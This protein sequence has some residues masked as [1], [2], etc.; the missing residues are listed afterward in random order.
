MADY[1]NLSE[2][3]K[4]KQ[5]IKDHDKGDSL[6]DIAER[7]GY[8]IESVRKII[9]KEF[10]GRKDMKRVR[11]DGRHKFLGSSDKIAIINC[12][13]QKP[14]LN[15]TIIKERLHLQAQPRSI[16]RYLESLHYKYIKPYKK[17]NLTSQDKMNR[18]DWALKHKN[19]DF[20]NVVFADECSIWMHSW[21]GKMWLKKG[22][23]HYIGTKAYPKVHVW[24]SIGFEGEV[25][26]HVFTGNLTAPKFIAI[27]RE[28]LI[29]A[30]NE[31]YGEGQWSL[32]QDNDPKH[33]AKKT[34]NFLK[35]QNVTFLKLF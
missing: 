17:P 25:G 34:E 20:S 12:V 27:L 21:Q 10:N 35:S 31:I 2:E 30:A 32:A 4:R 7:S 18:V 23:R 9:I 1:S 5:I 8:H 13:R 15:S 22:S 29:P 28:S 11:G 33:R 19:Y 14:W 26:I 3:E 16:R 6:N 24:G